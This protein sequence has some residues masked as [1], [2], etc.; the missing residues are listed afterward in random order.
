MLEDL[1]VTNL[2]ICLTILQITAMPMYGMN[3]PNLLPVKVTVK[4][5]FSYFLPLQHSGGCSGSN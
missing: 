4:E 1:W 2:T 3:T 5:S